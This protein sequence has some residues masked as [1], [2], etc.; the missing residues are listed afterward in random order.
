[1]IQ[2]FRPAALL[3]ALVAFPS[4]SQAPAPSKES[5]LPS[6]VPPDSAASMPGLPRNEAEWRE[7]LSPLQYEVLR[8]EGTEYSGTGE[9]L[10]HWED[11]TYRCAGCGAALYDSKVK[12]EDGGWPNFK[13]ALP[14][15]VETRDVGGYDEVHCAKCQGHLGHIFN[16]GPGPTK[17]RH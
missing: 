11:G 8:E 17:K 13:E 16:D 12:F 6:Q 5:A 7:R 2:L 1:M 14:G 15:A 3:L 4:C 10:D 9:F